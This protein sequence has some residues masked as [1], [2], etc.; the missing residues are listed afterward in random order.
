MKDQIDAYIGDHETAWARSTLKS[1]RARLKAVAEQLSA[2]PDS[3][4]GYL[5]SINQKPYT[6]KTTFIR[7]CALEAWIETSSLSTKK[8]D[9]ESRKFREFMKKHSNRFKHAYQ[10]EE[11]EITF[12]EALKRIEQLQGK[13]RDYARSILTTGLRISEASSSPVGQVTGKGGKTRKVYGR[14]EG[15]MPRSTFAKEL[16]KVGLKPHTLRKLCATRLA[17]AGAT[18]ADLCKIFGWSSI[19]T[20][21]QYLQAK[22]DDKIAK[23]MEACT[24]GS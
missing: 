21:Y 8:L 2:G 22:D 1:E 11:L 18:P 9:M 5:K 24:K 19:G 7:I 20:A 17:E 6:I 14:I 16:A 15:V 12:D 13:P 23:L 10:K 3:L 4:Y